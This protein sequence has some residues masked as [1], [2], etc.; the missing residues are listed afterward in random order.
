MDDMNLI[1]AVESAAHYA[2]D[3]SWL[4][5]IDEVALELRDVDNLRD[6]HQSVDEPVVVSVELARE[7]KEITKLAK[8]NPADHAVT[9]F[10]GALLREIKS[11]VRKY[12]HPDAKRLREIVRLFAM[13]NSEYL[14]DLEP[15]TSF[16]FCAVRAREKDL[17]EFRID[18]WPKFAIRVGEGQAIEVSCRVSHEDFLKPRGLILATKDTF[19]FD[20]VNIIVFSH[21]LERNASLRCLG[22]IK[23]NDTGDIRAEYEI[24]QPFDSLTKGDL[25]ILRVANWSNDEIMLRGAWTFSNEKT[26]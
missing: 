23:N 2:D 13:N 21:E 14:G 11:S 10:Y 15:E 5:A 8:K 3:S 9:K 4:A 17:T 6:L 20:A 18:Q 7:L 25:L 1:M 16:L 22:K 19:A 26:P 24:D 12:R